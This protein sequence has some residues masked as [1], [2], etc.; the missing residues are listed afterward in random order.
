MALHIS[1]RLPW[2]DNGYS[3]LEHEAEIPCLSE[4]GC[5]MS[6]ETYKKTTVHPYKKGNRVCYIGFTLR[7]KIYRVCI[8]VG[9]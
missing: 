6:S 1:V 5:F 3:I 7:I 2:K 9:G 4:G 8:F